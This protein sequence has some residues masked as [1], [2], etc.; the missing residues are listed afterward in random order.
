M[1]MDGRLCRDRFG[2]NVWT[3]ESHIGDDAINDGTLSEFVGTVLKF[4]NVDTYVVGGM[5]LILN[6]QPQ[7]HKLLDNTCELSVTSAQKHTIVHVN[8]KDN[9]AT[10]ENTIVHF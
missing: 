3:V 2:G 8:N 9:I 5:S 6:V 10:V 1:E 4:A 7:V